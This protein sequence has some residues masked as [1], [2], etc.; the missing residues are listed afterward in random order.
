L[1]DEHLEQVLFVHWFAK[2]FEHT[3]DLRNNT[4][5]GVDPGAFEDAFEGFFEHPAELQRELVV[6]DVDDQRCVRWE[7]CQC[8][9]HGELEQHLAF[10]FKP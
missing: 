2:S 9:E 6:L 3:H 4:S 7:F 10:G 1:V 5:I 8:D